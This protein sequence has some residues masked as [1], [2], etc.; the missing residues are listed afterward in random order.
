MTFKDSP[1]KFKNQIRTAK[2]LSLEILCSE[3]EG[4]NEGNG[5]RKILALNPI[6]PSFLSKSNSEWTTSVKETLELLM[7]TYFQGCSDEEPK[8]DVDPL[9]SAISTDGVISKGKELT[10]VK[11]KPFK[12]P[13][14]DDIIPAEM[15]KLADKL[16]LE[17]IFKA[18]LHLNYAPKLWRV[19]TVVFQPK[20]GKI[21]H[22]QAKKAKQANK[23]NFLSVK[24]SG[25]ISG[26]THL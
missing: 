10:I 18:C 4:I 25:K 23:S 16:W 5:L 15:Q 19:V 22:S 20:A 8:A 2:N 9:R 26:N 21:S 13:G 14:P 12:P 3:I 24:G 7:N 17:V 1:R 6:I 11:F